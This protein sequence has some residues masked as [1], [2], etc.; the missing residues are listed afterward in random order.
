MDGI[1]SELDLESLFK[2]TWKTLML[3]GRGW[4]QGYMTFSHL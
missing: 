2:P 4:I 1:S 3:E